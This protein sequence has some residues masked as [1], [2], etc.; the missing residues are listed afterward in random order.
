MIPLEPNDVDCLLLIGPEL[1][2]DTEAASQLQAGLPFLQI[3]LVGPGEFALMVNRFFATDRFLNPKGM[4]E[5]T[6]WK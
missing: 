5:L 6:S 2:S 3:D 1:P 4:V